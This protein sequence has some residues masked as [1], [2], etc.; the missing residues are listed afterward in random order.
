MGSE[1]KTRGRVN[2]K[3]QTGEKKRPWR[4]DLFWTGLLNSW[5]SLQDQQLTTVYGGTKPFRHL[6]SFTGLCLMKL[7][8]LE[9]LY[10]HKCTLMYYECFLSLCVSVCTCLES[11][12]QELIDASWL[13]YCSG[14]HL[15]LNASGTEPVDSCKIC[16]DHGKMEICTNKRKPNIVYRL[17]WYQPPCPEFSF[18]Q[19]WEV[20]WPW[21]SWFS[22]GW[23]PFT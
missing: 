2:R 21:P 19:F 22:A 8:Q 1:G 18:V 9:L 11:E 16:V 17:G 23:G 12:Q 14:F 6:K 7:L 13:F 15:M 20:I 5:M 4:A 3:Q 10:W